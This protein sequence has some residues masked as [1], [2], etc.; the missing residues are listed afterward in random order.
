MIKF[1]LFAAVMGVG[2]C[3]AG[4]IP[5]EP[6]VSS[7]MAAMIALGP[8]GCNMD[9]S[10]V[11][12]SN[13]NLIV[14][15][16]GQTLDPSLVGVSFREAKI[17]PLLVGFNADISEPPSPLDFD[18]TFAYSITALRGYRILSIGSGITTYGNDRAGTF[19]Y[20]ISRDVCEN[21]IYVPLCTGVESLNQVG[22]VWFNVSDTSRVVSV[23]SRGTWQSNETDS[24]LRFSGIALVEPVPEPNTQLTV[25]VGCFALLAMRRTLGGAARAVRRRERA[26]T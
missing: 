25:V 10:T 6:C 15:M 2:L 8:Q 24:L 19:T 4:S 14:T 18:V 5:N 1:T 16:D 20:T 3:R 13:F 9:G 7:T 12:W 22:D 11:K 21:G 23:R 26:W 17:G